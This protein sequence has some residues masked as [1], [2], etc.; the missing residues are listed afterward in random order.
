SHHANFVVA[1]GVDNHKFTTGYIHNS[2]ETRFP[3]LSGGEANTY[4]DAWATDILNP[5]EKAWS[6][7]YD[8]DFKNQIP[9]LKLM[10][11]YTKGTDIKL[12]NLKPGEELEERKFGIELSYQFQNT[13][14]KGL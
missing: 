1:L 9:G 12:E 13:P 10:T 4:I 6:V 8:Y 7:R 14:V 2:G 5:N 3:Y 11:R